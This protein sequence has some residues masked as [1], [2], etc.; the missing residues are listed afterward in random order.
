MEA[1][2]LKIVRDIALFFFPP[3]RMS[4]ILQTRWYDQCLYLLSV[5]F[6]QMSSVLP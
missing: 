6:S 5:V 2:G 1:F 4:D 3:A